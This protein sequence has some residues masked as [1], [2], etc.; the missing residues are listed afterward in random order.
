[1]IGRAEEIVKWLFA[2]DRDKLFECKEFKKRRSLNANSY[3]HALVGKIAE[4]S[5]T[6]TVEVKNALIRDYGQYHYLENG[7]LDWSI[8]PE[9]FNYLRS[10]TEH[11]QPT[12]RYMLDKGKKL[13]V[14]IVM[15]GSHTYNTAEMA[16]LI[17]G[18]VSE[19]K[20]LGI[21]TLPPD[22][23]MRLKERWNARENI[24]S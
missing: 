11:Y 23:L 3:F 16:R 14:Y 6:S 17:D 18:T 21:E 1:M 5:Q 19:A 12:D 15:R 24:N 22:E 20:E 9:G 7:T 2:Q 10:E 8:K 13:I 4:A